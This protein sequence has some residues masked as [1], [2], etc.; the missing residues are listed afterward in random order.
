LLGIPVPLLQKS[1]EEY[2]AL[3]RELR[4]MKERSDVSPG[5]PA[6]PERLEVLV[7]G[8]G[9]RFTGLGPGVDEEWQSALNNRVE[10][11]DW[12]FE[13]PQSAAVTCEFYD[14]MLD[15]ADEF[16]TS[17]RLLTLPA[18]PTSVAVRRWFNS[19][20]IRQL[21]GGVPVAWADSPQH[22]ELSLLRSL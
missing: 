5:V 17:A 8:L 11:F 12:V 6:L 15:E 9:T 4:L 20:L 18:S 22:A 14:T 13:L 7:S 16:A 3:F 10:L 1:S 21:R 19:E 2:E